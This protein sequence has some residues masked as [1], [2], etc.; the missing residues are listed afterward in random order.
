MKST[1]RMIIPLVLVYLGATGAQAADRGLRERSFV[2]GLELFDSAKSA[3]D[4]RES[5]SVLESTLEGGF[6]NGAIYYNLG[7]AYFRAGDYG[8]AIL[9]YRKAR[10]YRP[11]DPYLAANLQQALAVAPG[12]L[13]EAP[14]HWWTH[15]L[16]W[17]EWLALPLKI[18]STFIGLIAAAITTAVA[19]LFRWRRLQLLTGGL[20]V[21]SIALGIDAALCYVEAMDTNRAVITGET[22]A[23][24]GTGNSY[25]PAFDQPLKDGAEFTVLTET[26]GWTFGHFESIGDGWVRNEFVAR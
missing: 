18:Q 9:N 3:D 8:R 11:R 17:T 19:V 20:L 12:R 1:H 13:T 2:R 16:F 14:K 24:K 23:R 7:N 15:V 21:I 25:E 6:R 4:Y 5:A 22:I 10:P 26:P